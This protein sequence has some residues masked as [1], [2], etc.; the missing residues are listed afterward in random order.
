MA[1]SKKIIKKEFWETLTF[2]QAVVFGNINSNEKF[3][4]LLLYSVQTNVASLLSSNKF[5]KNFLNQ[6]ITG[7]SK[8]WL[9]Q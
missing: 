4:S 8:I 5:P 3:F 1:N 2:T 9:F 7:V 6:N